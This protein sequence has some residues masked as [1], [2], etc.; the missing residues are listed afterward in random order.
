MAGNDFLQFLQWYIVLLILGLV[1]LPLTSKIFSIFPDK[2]YPFSK[3]LGLA[4]TSF[5]VFNL[6]LSRIFQFD[7]YTILICILLMGGVT[8]ALIVKKSKVDI[9]RIKNYF[10]KYWK[11][12]LFEEIL[13]LI[14]LYFL[15]YIR[16]FSPDIHGLEKYMDF[17]FVNSIMRADFFPPKDMWF[18]PYSINYYYFGH[19]AT[20]VLTKISLLKTEVTYNLMLATIFAM[21]ITGGFSIVFN[22]ILHTSQKARLSAYFFA[23]TSALILSLGGNLHTIY[24]FFA[25]YQAES[26]VP[27][28]ELK[29]QPELFPNS[30]WYPNATRFIYNTIHEFPMYSWTVSD[31]HGHV[32]DIPFVILTLA[33]IL[34][35]SIKHFTAKK[36]LPLKALIRYLVLIGLMISVMYMTNAWDGIIYLLFTALIALYFNW[37]KRQE[38][39]GFLSLSFFKKNLPHSTRFSWV[40]ESFIQLGIVGI[41][42]FFFTLPFSISFKPFVS[43]IGILCAPN[44]LVEIG[45]LGPFLF[46]ADHC[47]HSL[48]WQLLI[49]HG[50]FI[51]FAASF[52]IFVNKIKKV[53]FTDR[54]VVILICLSAL[55][56]LIPEFIYAKD[57]YPGHYRANTMFKLVFQSFIMLSISTGYII[58][59]ILSY[60]K[61]EKLKNNLPIY[62]F[63][64]LTCI[65]LALIFIYPFQA[66]ES[67]YGK[68]NAY[69]GLD[70]TKYLGEIYPSDYAAINFINEKIP[71]QPVILEAQGD[72]YNG[73]SS[74]T[75]YA[76][77]SSNTGLPT[78]LGWTV[79]E[80]LWRG[81]YDIPAPRIEEVRLM[82]ES[83]SLEE[84]K[85]L[86]DKYGVEYIF[87]GQLEREKY[88]LLKTDKLR[89]LGKEIFSSNQT[90]IIKIN[91]PLRD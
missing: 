59:R 72:A 51:F 18:T 50:F 60:A 66:I 73:A 87:I 37:Q 70:G 89:S 65:L 64:A 8:T 7:T 45:S 54:F 6:G 31:L 57:I 24:T 91:H 40:L 53:T 79:H 81:T 56:I 76:R 78:V 80:W 48:W 62:I 90:R 20:A 36:G 39:I 17:G 1:F 4:L 28:W 27:P 63:K 67:Y 46:E 23:I 43:G 19:L 25:P 77:V 29:F 44:F 86:L 21:C 2:G 14:S 34:V 11:V 84:T 85:R 61:T 47:Q 88:P 9:K 83:D 75:D 71:G 49:L 55:L 26:P 69:K 15:T 42:F 68:L 22:L 52:L 33:I 13:F 82:Y 10:H 16:A 12:I 58:F 41:S 32:L 30:Y 35:F 5:A 74:Y 38:N 3:I